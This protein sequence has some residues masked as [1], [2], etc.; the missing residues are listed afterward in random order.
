MPHE[1]S[2]IVHEVAKEIPGENL[3]IHCHND[4]GNAVANSLAAVEAGARQIQG[5]INGLGERCGNA[6]LITLIPTLK[7]KLGYDVG[8]SDEGMKTLVKS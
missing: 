8:I 1:I 2:Q 3:G 6:N 4:S 5:T 7:I